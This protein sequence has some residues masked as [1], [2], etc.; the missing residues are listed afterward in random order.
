MTTQS[1]QTGVVRIAIRTIGAGQGD[2]EP[3]PV[4]VR[5]GPPARWP[6]RLGRLWSGRLHLPARPGSGICPGRRRVITAIG[7]RDSSTG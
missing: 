3:V 4:P 2:A 1:G 7:K 5:Y 6:R